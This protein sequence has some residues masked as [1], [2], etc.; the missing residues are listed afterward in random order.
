MKCRICD[1]QH[2]NTLFEAREM[3]FGTRE[4]FAYF[5][6]SSCASLQIKEIPTE[7]SKFYAGDYYSFDPII[8]RKLLA[9]ILKRVKDRSAVFRKGMF[10]R[11][12][13]RY[14]G[15]LYL[16]Q[17]GLLNPN[18]TTSVIDIGCGA[19]EFLHSLSEIG[20]TQL[21]GVDPHL[22]SEIRYANGLVIK[23]NQFHEVDGQ[24]DVVTMN[25]SFEH[26]VNPLSVLQKCR[27]V[28]KGGG[29]CCITTPVADSFAWHTY[30]ANWVQLDAPRHLHVLSRKSMEYLAEQTGFSIWRVIFNSAAFQF[31]GS[32][33]YAMDIPLRDS[34]SYGSNRR[35]SV[36]TNRDIADFEL[37]S[38]NLNA[39]KHGD[40]ATFILQKK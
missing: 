36:F 31:W 6:C 1:N 7:L 23:N 27:S 26:V 39:I 30:R 12:L 10:G 20:F 21:L 32:E 2:N 16:E 3:M 14:Y 34:R 5:E 25:H 17:L 22:T 33:Q 40:Q 29:F 28:L 38:R 8:R 9:G 13:N 18:P 15:N 35:K 4:R 19:G 24:Y 11:I 37:A